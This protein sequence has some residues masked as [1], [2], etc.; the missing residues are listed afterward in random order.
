MKRKTQ[1]MNAATTVAGIT[2]EFTKDIFREGTNVLKMLREDLI[3]YK[4]EKN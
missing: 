4:N 3:E 2:I 1:Y